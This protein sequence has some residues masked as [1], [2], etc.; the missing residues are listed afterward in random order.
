[1]FLA[2]FF[3]SRETRKD[4]RRL[5]ALSGEPTAHRLESRSPAL[6][7]TRPTRPS[8]CLCCFLGFVWFCF[9]GSLLDGRAG[10]SRG[11]RSLQA[12]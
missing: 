8:L 6:L 4:S 12:V 10:L 9:F 3:S 1:M 7:H 5:L 2:G 11:D